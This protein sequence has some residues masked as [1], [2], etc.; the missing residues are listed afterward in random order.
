[1]KV[2]KVKLGEFY[3]KSVIS[4]NGMIKLHEYES[5]MKSLMQ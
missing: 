5:F 2:E 1:M 4:I 3:N